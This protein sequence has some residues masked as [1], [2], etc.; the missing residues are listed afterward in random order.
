MTQASPVLI[1]ERANALFVNKTIGVDLQGSYRVNKVNRLYLPDTD[2]L[3]SRNASS[4]EDKAPSENQDNAK[5][6]GNKVKRRI[7][8]I[9]LAESL[10]PNPEILSN[11]ESL[12]EI[13][14]LSLPPLPK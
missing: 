11:T 5:F 4:S 2:T 8:N 12:L 13:V 10:E 6:R 3:K 7:S 14:I 1:P 9:L